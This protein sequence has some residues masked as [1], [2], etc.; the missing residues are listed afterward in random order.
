MPNPSMVVLRTYAPCVPLEA[1]VVVLVY[2]P[3]PATDTLIEL[4]A[5]VAVVPL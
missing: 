4:D 3:V 2:D 1:K 5:G